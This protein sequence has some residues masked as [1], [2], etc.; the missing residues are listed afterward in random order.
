MDGSQ[1]L[2][3]KYWL[4]DE[5]VEVT[6]LAGAS[7]DNI[8]SALDHIQA[9]DYDT[10]IQ[11]GMGLKAGG[12]PCSMWDDWSRK[13]SKYVQG[14]C[15]RRWNTFKGNRLGLGTVIHMAMQRGWKFTKREP[16]II[17]PATTPIVEPSPKRI[18]FEIEEW[19][20]WLESIKKWRGTAIIGFRT[21]IKVLNDALLGI[22]G[23]TLIAAPPNIGK[24]LL[25]LQLA[26]EILDNHSDVVCLF[27]TLEMT[28]SKLRGRVAASAI[29][30][31]WKGF[32]MSGDDNKSKA[33]FEKTANVNRRL[34]MMDA[35]EAP[36]NAKDILAMAARAREQS[37]CTRT[38][39][40]LDYLQVWNAGWETHSFRNLLDA[41]QW[42]VE[43][44]KK[45]RNVLQ[46]D[47]AIMVVSEVTKAS[48]KEDERITNEGVM[49][50]SRAIYAADAVILMQKLRNKEWYRYFNTGASFSTRITPLSLSEVQDVDKTTLLDHGES[51]RE[52]CHASNNWPIYLEI[53]KGRDGTQRA[54]I[55]ITAYY[56]ELT[57]KAGFFTREQ[58]GENA[59]DIDGI[60]K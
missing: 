59:H 32:I 48:N 21:N 18:V 42:T 15:Q 51:C 56:N 45:V 40:C 38:L 28:K 20:A 47:D 30:T 43:E 60:F 8:R 12:M 53:T 4:K 52:F 25:M 17:N 50:T 2:Y 55:P 6:Q 49:G 27:F 13:S 46:E 54:D 36:K 19:P 37:G 22:R 35:E 23:L 58:I 26:L 33:A 3:E 39:I 29:G 31:T 7:E 14:E 9:D 10:W 41:D 16:I 5:P 24:T 57:M 44:L 1:W 34:T 11:V